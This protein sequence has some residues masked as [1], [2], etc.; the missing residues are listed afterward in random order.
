MRPGGTRR[1]AI[2]WPLAYGKPGRDP[3]PPETDLVFEI[4][5]LEVRD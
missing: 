5:L 1:L 4:H 3:I 2:P